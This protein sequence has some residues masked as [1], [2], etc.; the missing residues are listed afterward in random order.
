MATATQPQWVTKRLDPVAAGAAIPRVNPWIS[1]S[2]M[3]KD[4][5]PTRGYTLN[6]MLIVLA[7]LAALAAMAWPSLRKPLAKHQLSS[8][9]KQLRAELAGMRLKAIH[10]G[11]PL[12]FRYV[13]GTGQYLL[14]PLAGTRPAASGGRSTQSAWEGGFSNAIDD[15]ALETT[16]SSAGPRAA[17]EEGETGALPADIVFAGVQQAG[18][19]LVESSV[20]AAT[21]T[22][23]SEP[24]ADALHEEEWSAPVYFF[25]NGR[26]SDAEIALVGDRDYQIRLNLRGITGAVTVGSVEFP[27]EERDGMAPV[28]HPT[29]TADAR[30]SQDAQSS[31]WSSFTMTR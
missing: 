5:Q 15:L 6:E 17:Q 10:R 30:R 21:D 20:P 14:E 13:P 31:R 7:V 8:A 28:Q 11:E 22:G 26:T 29:A 2:G 18:D 27:S 9:A 12:Q 1:E 16:D 23:A 4:N 3:Q 24:T 25:P 19:S